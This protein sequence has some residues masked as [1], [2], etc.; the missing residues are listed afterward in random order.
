MPGNDPLKTSQ[1]LL[2]RLRDWRDHQ[3]WITL[4]K[5][6]DALIQATCRRS[7]LEPD[8]AEEV[9]QRVLCKLAPRL[10]DFVYD[11]ARTFR[12]WL[13]QLVRRQ[14]I[15]YQRQN[16]RAVRARGNGDQQWLEQ[17]AA[18]SGESE[19]E[20]T[21]KERLLKEMAAGVEGAVRAQISPESWQAFWLIE[22]AGLSTKEAADRLGKSFAATYMAAQR[23][24]RR[25]R[26]EGE[27]RLAEYRRGEAGRLGVGREVAHERLPPT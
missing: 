10:R 15:D 19:S 7:G 8:A 24:G 1:S 18:P 9:G 12:G 21:S 20:S 27:K 3:A 5:R 14:A 17:I 6:Y 4:V 2:C 23:T 16:A 26:R 25:L 22:I 13:R 11:P